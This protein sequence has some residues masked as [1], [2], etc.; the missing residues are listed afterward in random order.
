MNPHTNKF[1]ALTE[2]FLEDEMKHAEIKHVDSLKDSLCSALVRPDGSPVP[3]SWTVLAVGELVDVKGYT[4]KVAHIGE[5]HLL[6]EPVGIPEIE[7]T[8]EK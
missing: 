2:A 6:L 1:E 8:P 7:G 5:S 4:F 3:S